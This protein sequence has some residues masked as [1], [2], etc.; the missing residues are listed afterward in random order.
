MTG[1]ADQA[2]LCREFKRRYA[3]TPKD[4]RSERAQPPAFQ[5]PL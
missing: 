3:I 5:T 4:L 2:H 1:F